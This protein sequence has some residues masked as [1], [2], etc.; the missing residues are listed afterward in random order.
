M[1]TSIDSD[2]IPDSRRLSDE[3]VARAAGLRDVLRQGG[4]FAD[5]NRTL[6]PE[7]VD[8]LQAAD[9][10]RLCVPKRFGGLEADV[11]TLV[12][13]TAEVARG[14]G[15]AG[16]VHALIN[17]AAWIAST[18]SEQAQ[19]DVWGTNPD[20]RLCTVLNPVEDVRRVDG[21]Y[22]V[23]GKWPFASGS[24]HSQWAHLGV[25]T[26]D[27][28]GNRV[29][30]LALFPMDE[31]EIVDTWFVVGM[32][33]TASNTLVARDVFVP[34]HRVQR[35]DDLAA[36]IYA[37]SSE[38]PVHRE[39]F[40]P[41]LG[42]VLCGAQL[43]LAQAAVDL[44]LANLPRRTVMY[45]KYDH[46]VDAPANR[47]GIAEAVSSVDIAT[48]VARRAC[49]DIVRLAHE[50]AKPGLVVRARIRMDTGLAI[51]YSRGAIN[52]TLTMNGAGSFATGNPLQ[53]I[54]RDSEAASRHGLIQPEIATEIYGRALFGDD[55]FVMP[56]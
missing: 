25:M 47:T 16:W 33:G 29:Q 24:A 10:Y 23:S 4:Q 49:D 41:V 52:R 2:V 50:G 46:A 22:V 39:S 45:S 1:A 38:A 6:S 21:G 55:E 28:E 32:R 34:D 13:T 43:G 27:D 44:T 56:I 18:Y 17:S 40:L 20:A 9:L 31:L 3:L 12:E 54:W 15:S 35:Y 5:D 36:D 48:M 30:S 37:T 42:V 14:D 53:R 26:P 51:T 19:Q 11:R 7:V 8:A